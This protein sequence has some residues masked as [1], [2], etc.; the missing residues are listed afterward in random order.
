M[1]RLRLEFISSQSWNH[2]RQLLQVFSSVPLCYWLMGGRTQSHLSPLW[3]W[4]T[5]C[6][7]AGRTS[8]CT[9]PWC[10]IHSDRSSDSSSCA[11][12][13]E[14]TTPEL[15]LFIIKPPAGFLSETQ[16]SLCWNL[17][18]P[19]SFIFSNQSQPE[20]DDAVF[21]KTRFQVIMCPFSSSTTRQTLQHFA[22]Y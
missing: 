14:K 2:V 15:K 3:W 20:H 7:P 12:G 10:C 6:W 9:V 21:F 17:F 8:G 18:S 19:V 4:R 22:A 1:R 13:G 16:T 5:G 11:D